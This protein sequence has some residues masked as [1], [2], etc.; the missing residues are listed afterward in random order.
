LDRTIA[1]NFGR[2]VLDGAGFLDVFLPFNADAGDA[3]VNNFDSL[4][5]IIFEKYILKF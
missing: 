5:L 1:E 3:E 4:A 2:H